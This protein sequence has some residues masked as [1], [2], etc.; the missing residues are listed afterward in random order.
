M[1]TNKSTSSPGPDVARQEDGPRQHDFIRASSGAE[2]TGWFSQWRLPLLAFGY[3]I[4]F[5]VMDTYVAS[6]NRYFIFTNVLVVSSLYF[7]WYLGGRETMLYV[8]F[9][10]IFF[11][12]IFS[13]FI[14]ISDV[15][16]APLFLS[17]SFVTLYLLTIGFMFYMLRKESPADRRKRL[18]EQ[19]IDQ[20]RQRRRQL[21]L[22]VATQKVTNDAVRQ[23][24]RVKDELLLL[25]N[26]WRSQIHS[27]V[28]DLPPVKE[29]E[30][31]DQ[32]VKPF[33]DDIIKHLRSLEQRLSFNPKSMPLTELANYLQRQVSQTQKFQRSKTRIL[34]EDNGW[35]YSR[36]E[37]VVDADK[38]WEILLNLVRNAQSA[39][40]LRQIELLRQSPAAFQ[41]FKPAIRVELHQESE[42]G[43][44]EITDTGG[45]LEESSLEQLFHKPLPSA[46]RGRKAMG[47]GT[48]FIKFFG[49][50]MGFKLEAKNST[51]LGAP[52]L[53]VRV[54][55]PLQGDAALASDGGHPGSQPGPSRPPENGVRS[56]ADQP[57]DTSLANRP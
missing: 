9:F 19:F 27:I 16:S 4:V 13:R 41:A 6:F 36:S 57:G 55:I 40:E 28:N 8:A 51:A 34:V 39:V 2:E 7:S 31:F 18:R 44:M 12:F 50:T 47:Q 56:A 49:E 23:A 48:I 24:N 14:Y 37:V 29:R 3:I 20:E 1:P 15:V 22:M 32:I 35:K 25:Q 43:V 5:V 26:S 54:L 42:H 53:R 45:G 17:K 33:Q 10:N 30:L 21:E 11:A 52:G 38:T 46:K